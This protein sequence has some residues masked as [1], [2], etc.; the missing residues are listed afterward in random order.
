[1]TPLPA[2]ILLV[3]VVCLTACSEPSQNVMYEGGKYAGKPDAP[4]WQSDSFNG[5]RDTWETAIK[6]RGTLQNEYT[7]LKGGG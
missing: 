1:M 2:S 5:S 4:A 7:R 3:A 6:K